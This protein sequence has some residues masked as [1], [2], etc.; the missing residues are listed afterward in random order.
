VPRA[1]AREGFGLR[2][3]PHPQERLIEATA[4]TRSVWVTCSNC[5]HLGGRSPDIRARTDAVNALHTL[6]GERP[7]PASG[8]VAGGFILKRELVMPTGR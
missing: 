3:A 4:A 2:V 1:G 5:K 7:K 6:A 8:K